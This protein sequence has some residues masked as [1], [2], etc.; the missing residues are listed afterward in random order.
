MEH[1]GLG[2]YGDPCDVSRDH[3]VMKRIYDLLKPNGRLLVT[4]PFGRHALTPLHRIYD[5]ESLRALVH[6]FQIKKI[7]YGVKVDSKRWVSPVTEE[8]A[9]QQR[10]GPVSNGPSAVA[11]ILCVKPE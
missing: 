9:S 11:M 3:S 7:Q 1:I 5:G 8:K 2:W 6:G 10:H 4:V